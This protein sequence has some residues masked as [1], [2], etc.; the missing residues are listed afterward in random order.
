MSVHLTSSQRRS[1]QAL[2]WLGFGALTVLVVALLA[3]LWLRVG[4]LP[5]L[6]QRRAQIEA[7]LATAID[8]PVRLAAIRAEWHGTNPRLSID[9]LSIL[10][11]NGAVALHLPS[12][13]ADISWR[14]LLFGQLVL[15]D[16]RS[17][18]LE[19]SL[20]R[21]V[22]GVV[23]LGDIP[24]NRNQG[25]NR[26]GDW[27]LQQRGLH[28]QDSVLHWDDALRG[29]PRLTLRR[30]D[31]RLDSRGDD[32]NFS[33]QALPEGLLDTPLQVVGRWTGRSFD[34]LDEGKG[35]LQAKLGAVRLDDWA[36][37]IDLPFAASGGA[38]ALEFSLELTGTTVSGF[39]TR[40]D[41]RDVG[42]QLRADL[43]RL[44][45]AELSGGLAYR[46]DAGGRSLR[47]DRLSM[48]TS[49]G[50]I[51][52]Q[53]TLSWQQTGTAQK[54][55]HQ[56]RIEH[57][58]LRPLFLLADS[59]PLAPELDDALRRAAPRG[60]L[61]GVIANWTG[62]W[63]EPAEYSVRGE[64]V[65]LGM[66]PVAGLPGFDRLSGALQA[67]NRQG[68]INFTV[69]QAPLLWPSNFTRAIPLRDA[70]AQLSWVRSGPGW[71]VTLGRLDVDTGELRFA[72]RGRY[73][74]VDQGRLELGIELQQA[75]ASAIRHYLP[76]SVGEATRSWF[77][78]AFPGR[79]QVT[80]KVTVD[81]VPAAFPY[82]GGVGGAFKAELELRDTSLRFSPTWPEIERISGRLTFDNT[83]M[84][85]SGASGRSL[86]ADLTEV[87]VLIPDLDA[88]DPQLQASGAIRGDLPAVL[89]YTQRSPVRRLIDGA[90]DTLGGNGQ[91]VV[92]LELDVPLDR[93]VDATV[94]GTVTLDGNRL[95]LGPGR[96]SLNAL[97]GVLH[98]TERGISGDNLSAQLFGGPLRASI[99]S[100]PGGVVR[101]EGS[102]RAR[103]DALAAVFPLQAW[104]LA[105][106][107]T[108]YRADLLLGPQGNRLVARSGLEGITLNLPQ[109][110]LKSPSSRLSTRFVWQSDGEA[111]RYELDLGEQIQAR[112]GSRGGRIEQAQ[113]ALGKVP[114]PAATAGVKVA[115]ELPQLFVEQWL[116]VISLFAT[117]GDTD[118]RSSLRLDLRTAVLGLEGRL[119]HDINLEASREAGPWVFRVRGDEVEGSGQW[120]PAGRGQLRARLDRLRLQRPVDSLN[121]P[122]DAD[123]EPADTYPDLDLEIARFERNGRDLGQLKL[124]ASQQG[125][126]WRI[127]E[128]RLAGDEYQL[129]ASGAWQSWRRQPS[130]DVRLEL[131]TTDTGRFLARMGYPGTMRGGAGTLAGELRWRGSPGDLDL[132]SLDG[133]LDL[134][135]GKG[136]FLKAEP[137][138]ARLLGII[139]LQALPRRIALDFRDVFSDGLA[140]DGIDSELSIKSGILRTSQLFIDG[141]AAK[142]RI[143]GKTDLARETQDLQVRVS[144]AMDAATIGALI[145]NPVAGLAVLLLQQV[146]D[147]PLGKL[148]TFN[149]RVGGTWSDPLVEK[150]QAEVQSGK[151]AEMSRPGAILP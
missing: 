68:R 84:T 75:S 150:Q 6:P 124:R 40:L 38:G 127:D 98:F 110:F 62:S 11:R 88:D 78:G 143:K 140:F 47:L 144:P 105:Q 31:M 119:F 35:Q 131:K 123:D 32:H 36:P 20:R 129:R 103:I 45:V 139:S 149:Y 111:N 106:G 53:T 86:L 64:F 145:A 58:L 54:P 46:D 5:E 24:L 104:S 94:Q 99:G 148:V 77:E 16:L 117:P 135:L 137:G 17:Q 134:E 25:D 7:G 10:D 141:P 102:G 44:E 116:P 29:A 49:D 113:V 92:R 118:Q 96:P 100:Q 81:G 89:D 79:G 93:S 30:L 151:D 85:L 23:L 122:A 39:D 107:E 27:L 18:G 120:D 56:V 34:R 3:L 42:F 132:A 8:R 74:A 55:R 63:S 76:V 71:A 82:T 48:R 83:R 109:P 87:R 1:R 97:G 9:G 80:G 2:R 26:F 128:L 52:P 12:I 121:A 51:A 15:G 142:V 95:D 43:P 67:D 136:Q 70:A 61:K 60:E 114:L 21:D 138:V 146:M 37:W 65:E 133:K 59:L 125:R 108:T 91:V 147:D 4:L 14:S 126:D 33:L 22:D 90:T 115:A 101:I 66:A 19:L 28:L 130:T 112:L 13:S 73:N 57:L 41:L 50:V 69:R 72:A